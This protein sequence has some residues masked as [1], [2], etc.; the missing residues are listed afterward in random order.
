MDEL[1][2]ALA[3]ARQDLEQAAEQLTADGEVWAL[4][5]VEAALRRVDEAAAA[6][7]RRPT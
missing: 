3:Q 4:R 2:R 5:H 6:L 1:L 7:A